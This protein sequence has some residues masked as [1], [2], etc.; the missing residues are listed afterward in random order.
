MFDQ[1]RAAAESFFQ[2]LLDQPIGELL[3]GL[4]EVVIVLVVVGFVGV[5]GW[6]LVIVVIWIAALWRQRRS[7]RR[8]EESLDRLVPHEEYYPDGQLFRKGFVRL[9]T[10]DFDPEDDRL[11]Y[12]DGPHEE[13]YPDGQL[14]RRGTF[15]SWWEWLDLF[16]EFWDGLY[17]EYSPN[18]EL[19][20]RG[21]YKVRICENIRAEDHNPDEGVWAARWEKCGEWF[22]HGETVT[23]DPCPPD[24]EN[25]LRVRRA[26][27]N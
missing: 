25:F 20:A 10:L 5:L 19:V 11:W 7:D 15:K 27:G 8:K 24:L 16:D 3:G 9:I 18:G 23:Y 26:R 12:W 6:G 1:L 4:F 17:E 13:Y 2:T 21:I 22:E 14:F